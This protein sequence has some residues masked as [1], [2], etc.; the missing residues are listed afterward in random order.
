MTNFTPFDAADYLD[1]E[2]TIAEYLLAA[3]EDANPDVFLTAIRDV[4]H[5]RGM[6]QFAKDAGID[7][8]NLHKTLSPGTKL[9]QDTM[10]KLFHALGM[11]SSVLS[12]NC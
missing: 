8:A 11:K 6:V 7:Y 12:I 4:A 10:S 3:I 5:A 1:D 9:P 2:E